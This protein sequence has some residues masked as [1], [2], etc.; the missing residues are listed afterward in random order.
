VPIEEDEELTHRSPKF[1]RLTEQSILNVSLFTSVALH[2]Y[3][4]IVDWITLILS[5]KN[6]NY[7]SP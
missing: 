4:I 6:I 2:Y 7:A 3:F 5:V 1:F